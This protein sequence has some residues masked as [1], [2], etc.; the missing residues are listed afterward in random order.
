MKQKF[1]VT[2][3][4]WTIFVCKFNK[5]WIMHWWLCSRL[6]ISLDS[7]NFA[8]MTTNPESQ[9]LNKFLL[10]VCQWLYRMFHH[11][12]SGFPF[13]LPRQRNNWSDIEWFLLLQSW[14]LI[15][16]SCLAP[17]SCKRAGNCGLLCIQEQHSNRYCWMQ[18]KMI[19]IS[20]MKSFAL[21]YFKIMSYIVLKHVD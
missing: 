4:L 11:L 16:T 9:W 17:H 19:T 10:Y 6:C 21:K 15:T 18:I 13:L 5:I 8:S 2:V 1:N 14:I 3:L 12:N 7:L 20:K